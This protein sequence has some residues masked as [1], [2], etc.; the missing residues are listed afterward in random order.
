M[1]RWG[2]QGGIQEKEVKG[3][4]SQHPP[5]RSPHLSQEPLR[6]SA[7]TAHSEPRA[8]IQ[9]CTEGSAKVAADQAA[10]WEPPW[11]S[12]HQGLKAAGLS[13][14]SIRLRSGWAD[15]G[16]DRGRPESSHPWLPPVLTSPPPPGVL[17][18]PLTISCLLGSPDILPG[19]LTAP[20][21]HRETVSARA[22]GASHSRGDT[23]LEMDSE[24]HRVRDQ[25][26]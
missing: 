21:A 8:G 11:T 26:L 22:T 25:G 1:A 23:V 20:A 7:F 6:P 19:D 17:A 16:A 2:K 10:H 15:S 4:L 12:P 5:H 14:S 13:W 3:P 9:L 18:P 24:L